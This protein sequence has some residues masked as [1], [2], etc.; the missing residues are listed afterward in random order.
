[1]ISPTPRQA[2]CLGFI[3]A[4]IETH[5]F[6]P[7]TEE[8]RAHLGLASKSGVVRILK[9]LQERGLIRRLR[10][11]A[12]AIEVVKGRAPLSTFTTDELVAELQRRGV[13]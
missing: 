3:G 10:D 4:F 12:R 11:R 7:S 5:G 13:A 8:M 9:E 6:A 2:E 1:M